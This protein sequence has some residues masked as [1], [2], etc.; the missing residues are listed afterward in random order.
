[1][2]NGIDCP[3]PAALLG[4]AT[5]AR[6]LP[7][8]CERVSRG[9]SLGE[10]TPRKPILPSPEEILKKAEAAKLRAEAARAQSAI[11]QSK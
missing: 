8:G 3:S 6:S 9:R 10:V 4:L 2:P 5:I 1:M 11:E 7:R